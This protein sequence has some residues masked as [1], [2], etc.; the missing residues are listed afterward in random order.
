MTTIFVTFTIPGLHSWPEAP[1]ESSYLRDSHR[2]LFHFRVE[3][4]VRGVDREVEFHQLRQD[5]LEMLGFHYSYGPLGALNFGQK[6]CES[7]A[8]D[9]L[10]AIRA[11]ESDRWLAVEV[12]ED[13]ECGAR[14]ESRS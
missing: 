4:S 10:E 5:C 6:S 9:L 8:L 11:E 12:S 7:I 2:H 3:M 13:G 1:D 14:V